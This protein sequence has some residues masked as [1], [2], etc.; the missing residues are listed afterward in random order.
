MLNEHEI[1]SSAE[2][3]VLLLD[4]YWEKDE[5]DF[6][7]YVQTLISFFREY[8]DKYH[9]FKEE[10]VLFPVLENHRDFMMNPLIS[11][12]NEHHAIF[13]EYS[14]KI[15]RLLNA[16]QF[17]KCYTTL[18]LYMNELLDHIGVEDDELFVMA[19]SLLTIDEL[20]LI[21]FKFRDIDVELGEDRKVELCNL[22]SDIE[23][24]IGQTEV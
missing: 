6:V 9:H 20:E 22:L 23:R 2:Q 3:S 21:Y 17:K 12:L 1:I 7:K 14:L 18:C 10:Q 8:G 4:R 24:E 16:N 19:V 13:R 11:E 15:E 5:K